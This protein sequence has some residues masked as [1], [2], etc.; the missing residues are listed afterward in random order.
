MAIYEEYLGRSRDSFESYE[1]CCK[2]YKLTWQADFNFA[3]DVIDKLAE[4]K[5]DKLALLYVADDGSEK[6]F[7][8]R[9]MKLWSN[10]AANCLKK[11]GIKK[12]D[13]VLLVLRRS[14]LFWITLLGMHKIGAIVVQANDMLKTGEYIYRCNVGGISAVILTG[15]GKCTEIYDEGEG[16]YEYVR[17]KMVT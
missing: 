8:F 7:T 1:D 3:Y 5:P 9:D 6:R 16:E 15:H 12:G 11:L 4:E 17:L 10:K 14:Y 13:R 2:N